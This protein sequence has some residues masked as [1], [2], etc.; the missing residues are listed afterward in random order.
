MTENTGELVHLLPFLAPL[1]LLELG[2]LIFAL[3]DVIRRK[4]V[5][6][7]NK[8]IWVIV[9]VVIEIIGPC[10]YLLFGRKEEPIDG[11]QD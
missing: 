7:N 5:R 1:I 4:Q 11:D 8:I 6:G 10:I 3:L 2:L 9:I